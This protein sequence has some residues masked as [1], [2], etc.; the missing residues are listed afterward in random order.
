MKTEVKIELKY[1]ERCGALFLHRS[2]RTQI[3]CASCEPEMRRMAAPT[4]RRASGE[5]CN[6]VARLSRGAVCA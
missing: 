2:D 6:R 1:C 5:R 3:Y 4:T